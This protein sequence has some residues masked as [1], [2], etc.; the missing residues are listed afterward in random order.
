MYGVFMSENSSIQA[1]VLSV[2]EFFHEKCYVVPNYQRDYAWQS[3]QWEQ[4]WDDLSSYKEYNK[5]E[6]FIG[7]VIVVPEKVFENTKL[8]EQFSI[9]D[10]QQRLTTLQ[11][12]LSSI[13]DEWVRRQSNSEISAKKDKY[14]SVDRTLIERLIITNNVDTDGNR[15]PSFTANKI[16]KEVFVNFIQ[17]RNH[18]EFTNKDDF[19]YVNIPSYSRVL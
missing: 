15:I 11:I 5:P 13:R 8:V 19:N 1:T 3:P 17:A 7:S 14:G 10:G 18:K 9:V 2:E 4:L 16:S 12:I 6:I